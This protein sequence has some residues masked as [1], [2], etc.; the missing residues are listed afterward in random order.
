MRPQ[1]ILFL[2][3]KALWTRKV[4]ATLLILSVTVGVATIVTLTSQTEGIGMNVITML[5][6]LGPD[7]IIVSASN[8][9]ITN[10]D[11]AII[12]MVEG[13]KEVI[14]LIRVAGTVNLGGGSVETVVYGVSSYGLKE[15]LGDVKLVEGSH[16]QDAATPLALVG[17]QIALSNT[18][19]QLLV[20]PGQVVMLSLRG[21]AVA[22]GGGGQTTS[23]TTIP[24]VVSGVLAQY[25][26]M[27]FI[28]PD[29]GIF[30]PIQAL[31]QALNRGWY[32]LLIVKAVDS[33]RVDVVVEGLRSIYGNSISVTSPSQ[34][35][36]T[37]QGV[38]TQLSLLLGGIAA[39]SL[40]TAALGI[41]NM[42]LV[43]ITERTREIGTMKA[44]GFKNR[45]ILAQIVTEGCLIGVLGG[46]AGIATGAVVSHIIPG[47]LTGGMM[48]QSGASAPVASRGVTSQIAGLSMT[49]TPYVNPYIVVAS[50]TLAVAVSAVSS[51]YPAWR[52]AKMDPVK[53]LRHE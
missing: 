37:M 50:F 4:R 19:S 30:M 45:H 51:V 38:I 47:L 20:L 23:S 21:G 24:L 36:Q 48:R 13:V 12:S 46:I 31:Q 17:N 9:R 27:L 22:V 28:S 32:D 18:T 29:T 16:Y 26:S 34:V 53:A 39:I 2:A 25:G 52:A 42:M 44:L 7:T 3:F 40:A 33:S 11:V 8:R 10:S 41:L 6:K 35:T 49:Y 1:D 43:T 15:L 5:Q 14:P